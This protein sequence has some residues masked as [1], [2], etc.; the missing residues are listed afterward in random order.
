MKNIRN[1]FLALILITTVVFFSCKKED[2]LSP[3][4]PASTSTTTTSSTSN[5]TFTRGLWRI[6]LFE[7]SGSDKT[8]QFN[9]YAFMFNS[10]GTI[11]ITKD[12][13]VINGYWLSD[14]VNDPGI[15][16]LQFDSSPLSVLNNRWKIKGESFNDLKLEHLKDVNGNTDNL[17]FKRVQQE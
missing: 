6:A 1:K 11:T 14:Q 8:N 9:G 4:R 2:P 15:F 5:P 17:T 12:S 16:L 7:D 3:I 13:S 10:N